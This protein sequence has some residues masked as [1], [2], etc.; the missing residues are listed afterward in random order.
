MEA[1]L[2]AEKN[3]QKFKCLFALWQPKENLSG[4]QF[5]R[6]PGDRTLVSLHRCPLI[7]AV[8]LWE[9]EKQG[10]LLHPHYISNFQNKKFYKIKK[11]MPK[12]KQNFSKSL[13]KHT[14]KPFQFRRHG[15]VFIYK[16]TPCLISKWM[17]LHLLL[18]LN[19]EDWN[20]NTE[21][22]TLGNFWLERVILGLVT[23]YL[24]LPYL[25]IAHRVKTL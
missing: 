23:S 18:K 8:F 21:R 4:C 17:S 25:F 22:K 13:V 20:F 9:L 1:P 7:P 19:V 6:T 3:T 2:F 16:I 14:M 5:K 24:G 15:L 11:Q 10:L 12:P